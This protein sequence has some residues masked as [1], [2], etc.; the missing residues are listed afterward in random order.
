[1]PE[2]P[3]VYEIRIRGRLDQQWRTWFEGMSITNRGDET[4]ISGP[5]ADQA[6]LHGLLGK[7]RDLGLQLVEMRIRKNQ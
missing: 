3:R 6:A 5:V 1:M 2:L 7:I 4:V